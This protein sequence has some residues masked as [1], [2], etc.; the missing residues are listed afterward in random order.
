MRA[1]VPKDGD[2]Y[3]QAEKILGDRYSPDN[4][5]ISCEPAVS[6]DLLRSGC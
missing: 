3:V 4:V 2:V 1:L 5:G 6:T